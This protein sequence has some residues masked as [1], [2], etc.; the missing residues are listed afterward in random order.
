M[1]RSAAS[2]LA[3]AVA[4]AGCA[5]PRASGAA[6]AEAECD[7][8]EPP[9]VTRLQVRRGEVAGIPYM[10]VVYGAAEVDD[11]LPMV[12]GIH[13][14]GDRPRL[15]DLRWSD[16]GRP[17]RIVMPQGPIAH[18]EGYAWFAVRVGDDEPERL[19]RALT[20]QAARLARA[21]DALRRRLPTVG[22]PVVAGGSQGGMMAL[23]LAVHHPE[24]VG[25]AVVLMAWLPPG[26]V[27][28]ALDDGLAYPPIRSLHGTED[29]IVPL[30]PT[31]RLMARLEGLG[32]DV[33]LHEVAG[34]GH[35]MNDEMNAAVRQWLVEMLGAQV[36]ARRERVSGSTRGS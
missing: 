14:L 17:Y 34:I 10:E 24:R 20:E 8:R 1:R 23:A 15:P 9:A 4:A 35:A 28:D 21:I 31:R 2:C 26:L 29:E 5:G 11:R 13:G 6:P 22:T 30:P 18:G 16:L 25:G 36:E 3:L 19:A 32:L 12:V 27:P 33:E 7:R